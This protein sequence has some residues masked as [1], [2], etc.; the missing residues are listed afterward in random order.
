MAMRIEGW[1]SQW[2]RRYND[3]DE[4]DD[5]NDDDDKDD[6]CDRDEYE[7]RGMMLAMMLASDV[8]RRTNTTLLCDKDP[9]S[10][11]YK[12]WASLFDI[13]NDV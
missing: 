8:G 4:E 9:S 3:N 10:Y 12:K 7:D 11:L 1:C 6:D 5:D 2:W 13:K